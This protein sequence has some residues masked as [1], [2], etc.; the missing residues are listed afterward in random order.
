MPQRRRCR[1]PRSA[2]CSGRPSSGPG[3]S[4]ASGCTRYAREGG[5][6]GRGRATTWDDPDAGVRGGGAR[7]RSTAT[8][9]TRPLHDDAGR[10]RRPDHPAGWS[11]ALG[12][13]LVQLTMPGRA[14][15]L[16]GHRAVGPLAG[17]PGQPAAGRLRRS[18]GPLL[19]AARRRLAAAGRRR[20]GRGQAAGGLAGRCG[21][22]GT[23][24]SCSPGTRRW[25]RPGRP[26]EHVVAFDRGGAVT[27]A[28]RLPVG[29][30]RDGGWRDTT[31]RRC[32]G[33]DVLTGRSYGGEIRA[34]RPAGRLP[35]RAAGA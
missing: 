16:P 19:A 14:G 24:R 13:K 4:T 33:T 30:E 25:P 35:G 12:Q 31:R 2:T 5:P 11:N 34:G 26:R 32:A 27:V 9:T 8:T 23:G 6:G 29:L 28:T 21:C 3:R 15:H 18:P 7:G 10:V 17:R 20:R 1:T 22:A